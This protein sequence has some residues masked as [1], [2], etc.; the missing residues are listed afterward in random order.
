MPKTL[1]VGIDISLKEA[2]CCFLNQNGNLVRKIF[3][4]DN[5]I[6]GF[7]KL[8]EE[9]ESAI[10]TNNFSLVCIG[11]EAT[12]MYGFHLL[13]YFSTTD[14]KYPVKV[15]LYQ[16]NAKYVKRFKKAFPEKEKTDI[17]DCQF[18]AEYLR[19]G[20]LPA[21]YKP[22]C[23]FLPL[24]RLVRYRY[25]IVK[26]LEREKKLYMA[27]LFLK[28]PGWVQNRPVATLGKT[29]LDITREFTLDQL[30]EMPL[31]KLAFFVAKAG[32]NRSG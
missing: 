32:K 3:G 25:H 19:F 4:V 14:F 16:I 27:N 9:I 17:V 1:F 23:L 30:A 26:N 5:N 8:K 2:I 11:L 15:K 7:E 20:K 24:R 21:E 28:F 22:E 31:E 10:P 12:S 6:S 18:I 29:A 13:D